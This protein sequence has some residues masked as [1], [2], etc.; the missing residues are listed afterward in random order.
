M[1]SVRA[2]SVAVF[3][4]SGL[5]FASSATTDVH[6]GSTTFGTY[7]AKRLQDGQHNP[8]YM[9]TRDGRD[10]S[11]CSDACAL[12]FMPV[13][14]R[15]RLKAHDGVKQKLLGSIKRRDGVRQVTYNHHPLY[16]SSNDVPGSALEDGCKFY[17]GRWY[18]LDKNGKPDTRFKAT[19]SG[20]Y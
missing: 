16:T 19:C 15:A 7:V 6:L 13:V 17:G 2:L 5:A 1:T 11:R 20:G 3:V 10:K 14:A 18:V 12:A 4:T 9:S 8:I